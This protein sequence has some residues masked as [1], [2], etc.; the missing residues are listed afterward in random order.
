MRCFVLGELLGGWLRDAGSDG[1]D[2]A[3][4]RLAILPGVTHYSMSDA[5]LLAETALAFLECS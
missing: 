4:H 3:R 2:M 1:A 5:P